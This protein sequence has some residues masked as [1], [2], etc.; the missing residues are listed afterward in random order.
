MAFN[1]ETDKHSDTTAS[2]SELKM[3][4]G[5]YTYSRPRILGVHF[6]FSTGFNRI[7]NLIM[8]PR[9]EMPHPIHYDQSIIKRTHILELEEMYNK[10]HN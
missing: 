10:I 9:Q 5:E 8:Y 1:S 7:S 2:L 6:L 4:K 3:N